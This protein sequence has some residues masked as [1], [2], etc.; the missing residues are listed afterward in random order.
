VLPGS[1]LAHAH[2]EIT[3]VSFDLIAANVQQ[4][5]ALA[6]LRDM[7]LPK[8]LSGAIQLREA[9]RLVDRAGA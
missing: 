2:N 8:L 3:R 6:E 5:R 4:N 1:A 9:E 7:L